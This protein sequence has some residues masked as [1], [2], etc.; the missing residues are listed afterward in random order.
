MLALLQAAASLL[1][2]AQSP[3]ATPAMM[4]KAIDIGSNTVQVVVQASAPIDFAVPKNNSIWPTT[5]DL[6]NSPYID[7]KG[8]W[9]Q[10]GPTVAII[11]G[12]TSFGDINNDGLDDAA[13]IVNKPG[14][15]G[16]SHYFL[17]AMLN[18]DSILFNIADFPL[19]N[20]L[21][22]TSHDI[23]SNKIVINGN[24]YEVLGRELIKAL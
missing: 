17:A 24:K 18:H 14:T 1:V 6:L 9:V 19:G 21:S 3:Q 4:Q 8:N 5:N 2:S 11:V 22:I 16:S 20:S 12:Y 10:L 15:N 13:V 7:D 23:V